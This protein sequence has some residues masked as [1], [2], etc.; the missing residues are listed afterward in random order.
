MPTRHLKRSAVIVPEPPQ[1]PGFTGIADV[2]LTPAEG[3]LW[4]T[5]HV[6]DNHIRMMKAKA[7]SLI[8]QLQEMV[9]ELN[10]RGMSAPISSLG[11]LR[12]DGV[13]LE[14]MCGEFKRLSDQVVNLNTL[15]TEERKL[16]E[17]V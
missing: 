8:A 13:E 14:I 7:F 1:I 10:A 5:G 12:H 9:D 4:G 6:L 3:L 17:A 16:K 11:V 2:E 15:V